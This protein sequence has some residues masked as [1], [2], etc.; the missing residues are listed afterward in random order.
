MPYKNVEKKR[1]HSKKN[2]INDK[3]D[4]RE[5]YSKSVERVK[6]WRLRHPKKIKAERSLEYAIRTGR[7]IKKPCSVCGNKI[8]HGHH[9]DYSKPLEVVWLCPLHHK[10]RHMLER[11]T[12]YIFPKLV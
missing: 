2:W 7:I 8:A 12:G 10:E 4:L 11:N 6:L 5:C 9:F 1:E 3:K